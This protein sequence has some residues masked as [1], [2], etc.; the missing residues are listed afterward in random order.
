MTLYKLLQIAIGTAEPDEFPMLDDE[1]WEMLQEEAK[2]QTVI[3]VAL[4]GVEKLPLEK[5][6]ERVRKLRWFASVEKIKKRNEKLDIVCNKLTMKMRKAGIETVVLKGQGV[7]KMYPQ[8]LYRSAG[9]IDLYVMLNSQLNLANG[10]YSVDKSIPEITKRIEDFNIGKLGKI[11]YH[12]I[13]W[14]IPGIEV[15]VHI[16]PMQFN[17]PWV[18]IRFQRWA[19]QE[20]QSAISNHIFSSESCEQNSK[21]WK[22]IVPT[23]EFNLVFML[24]HIYHHLLFEGVGLRQVMDYAVLLLSIKNEEIDI[25]NRVVE[26]IRS[27]KMMKFAKGMMWVMKEVF[28]LPDQALLCEPDENIGRFILN[29]IQQAGNFG[30]FDERIDHEKLQG[31]TV[32]KFLERTR[33]R[34]KFIHYFPSEI[35]WDIPFRI[36]HFFWRMKVRQ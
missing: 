4:G 1:Q 24:G 21:E 27:L 5:Q 8:P 18:N 23:A 9:D 12:H 35:L 16:R 11:V 26:K 15:E 2:K 6:P 29:E 28:N 14:E 22:Y 19:K 32:V 17:N 7:A 3:G 25:K 30:K 34:M 20:L 36:W 33:I 13:D 31:G 10:D